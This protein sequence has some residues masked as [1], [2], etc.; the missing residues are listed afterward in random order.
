[1]LL[2]CSWLG[3]SHPSF[4]IN[5]NFHAD[6]GEVLQVWNC[7]DKDTKVITDKGILPIK[8]L[9]DNPCQIING[10]GEWESVQFKP[11]GFSRLMKITLTSNNNEKVIYATPNHRWFIQNRKLE[12]LTCE[13][14]PK[15]RLERMWLK[16]PKE[17]TLIKE[18]L[19][20]GFIYG[21]G[22]H[23]KKVKTRKGYFSHTVCICGDIKYK[24]CVEQ[25]FDIKSPSPSRT[26][27]V[28]GRISH[29]CPYLA[30]KIPSCVDDLDYIFSF[31]AGYFVA[32]GNCSHQSVTLSSIH[33]EELVKIKHL[34]TI[35]GIATY[36]IRKQ[37]R[38]SSS[39]MGIVSDKKTH[40]QYIL[41][42]VK[43]TIPSLFW[44]S[45]KR[46]KYNSTYKSYLGYTVKSVEFTNRIEK[47][48]CCQTSTGSFV[49]DGFI[50]TGNCFSCG[51]SGTIPTLLM[52][53][54]PERFKS[55]GFAMNFLK[56]RYGLEF[57][58]F[59]KKANLR[60]I[61]RYGES[62]AV[63]ESKRQVQ[64]RYSLA[65]YKS[66]KETYKYFFNR[67]FSKEDMKEYM[68]G[69][70]LQNKTVTIPVFYEDGELAGVIGR[71]ISKNRAHN[72]RYKIYNFEKSKV[73]FPM[74]KVE[75]ADD[76]IIIVESQFDCM[77]MRK[78]GMKNVLATMGGTISKTQA[79]IITGKCS[80]VVLLFDNDDGGRKATEK[81]VRLLKGRVRILPFTYPD[82]SLGKDPSEWGKDATYKCVCSI[83]KVAIKRL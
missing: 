71:Y 51:S 13:L 19:L 49:L 20:H 81:A 41:G 65:V 16:Q 4:G 52:K 34:F 18:A 30:E 58:T 39:N 21:D 62:E 42:I 10:K 6:S 76:T 77:V 70:D 67:G 3:E 5:A 64:S 25:G 38:T 12:V 63:K 1:M 27:V 82:E 36:P 11:Y 46:P 48:Y 37:V 75:V 7:F 54:M 56:N 72:E 55:F 78:W 9:L 24:F 69:R 23:N 8:Y 14:K 59:K 35:L 26:D 33:E 50:L 79:N 32:D 45:D 29:V 31:L 2:S 60:H 53:A 61:K 83:G 15:Q 17:F 66:G 43:S 68:I 28:K 44:V 22:T 40:I 74:D 73:L 47:V 57:H 80:K